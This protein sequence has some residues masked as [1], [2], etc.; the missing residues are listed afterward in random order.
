MNVLLHTPEGVRDIYNEECRRKVIL[1]GKLTRML[2]LYGYQDIETPTFEFFD[3]FNRE[4]G[5]L[6]SR[7]MYKFIDRDGSTLVLRPDITPSIARAAAKY[8]MDESIPLK[9]AY[10]GNTFANT[11]SLQGNMKET[12]QIGAELIGDSSIDGD[13]ELIALAIQMLLSSGL[14]EFQLS[15]GHAGFFKALIEAAQLSD[16]DMASLRQLISDKNYFA[17]ETFAGS[18]DLPEG[19]AEL[20]SKLPQMFGGVSVLEEARA[21]TNDETAI[22]ILDDLSALY[23]KIEAYGF[24]RYITI[25]LGML[26]SYDYYTGIIMRGYTYGTGDAIVKGGRYDHLLGQFGKE[27]ASVGF[28]IV[29]DELMLA[30][31]RQKIDLPDGDMTTMILY[32]PNLTREAVQLAG[33][34]R[35]EGRQVSMFCEDPDKCLDDY[36]DYCKRFHMDCILRLV[37]SSVLHRIDPADGSVIEEVKP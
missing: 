14:K 8:F 9:F 6:P 24:A 27:A 15:I 18:L 20:L 32:R 2:H 35:A 21:L 34:L 3:I 25:D 16:E 37:E 1:S 29:V 17:V 7:N 33:K 5:T 30:L 11:S 26:S 19:T 4:R 12:T 22:N 36:M 28:V 10:C 31:S 13:A 23:Q